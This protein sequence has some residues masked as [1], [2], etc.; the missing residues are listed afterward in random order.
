MV[1]GITDNGK[2]LLHL[3]D[4]QHKETQVYLVAS[5]YVTIKCLCAQPQ[6]YINEQDDSAVL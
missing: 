3:L 4:H 5:M 2:P 1:I 6:P